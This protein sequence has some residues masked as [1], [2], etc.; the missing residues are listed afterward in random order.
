[1][2]LQVRRR[3][4]PADL[5]T[6]LNAVLG[7]G[8]GIIAITDPALAARLI[9]LATIVDALDGIVARHLGNSSVGPLLD[10]ITDVVS[11]GTTPGLFI[12]GILSAE[13]GMLPSLSPEKAALAIGVPALFATCSI[14]R[15]AFYEVHV[16]PDEARPGVPNALAAVI[17]AAAYLAGIAT[18]PLLIGATAILG[19]LMVGPMKYPDLA[20]RDALILGFVQALA[21]IAPA[22]GAGIFPLALLVAAVAYLLL[23]PLYYDPGPST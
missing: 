22:F 2:G 13:F 19:L 3:L 14:L 10:S 8:A 4:G 18:L 5:I 23:G 16:G 17:L 20:L 21:V 15:T 9:L 7:F 1:M 11:F 12:F 6:L